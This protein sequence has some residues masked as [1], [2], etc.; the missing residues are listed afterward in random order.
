MPGDIVVSV[1]EV[2]GCCGHLVFDVT[3][4]RSPYAEEAV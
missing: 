1:E 2:D 4:S 3:V